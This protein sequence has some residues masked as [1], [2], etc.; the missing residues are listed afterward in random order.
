ME[1]SRERERF[2]APVQD[3]E[4]HHWSAPRRTV[5]HLG[6]IYCEARKQARSGGGHVRTLDRSVKVDLALRNMTCG[7]EI[8]VELRTSSMVNA[9]GK[10]HVVVTGAAGHARR[11]GEVRSGL[12]RA[13]RLRVTG[14]AR[15]GSPGSAG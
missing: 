15:R 1:E 12:R 9:S 8:I 4:R 7:A 2:T 10:V 6:D 14:F 3:R 5:L 13:R 11:I